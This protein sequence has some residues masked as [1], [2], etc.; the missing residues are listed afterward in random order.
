MSATR[1]VSQDAAA[2][3]ARSRSRRWVAVTVLLGP[4]AVLA[5]AS[6]RLWLLETWNEWD[7]NSER[8]EVARPFRAG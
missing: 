8:A 3:D 4:A 5:I 2:R 7:M 6:D 1:Y